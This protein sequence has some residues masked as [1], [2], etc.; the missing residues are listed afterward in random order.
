MTAA[1]LRIAK[2]LW[3]LDANRRQY[4]QG[5]MTYVLNVLRTYSPYFGILRYSEY[6][7]HRITPHTLVNRFASDAF[8]EAKSA[9]EYKASTI[10]H[11]PMYLS[12]F[13]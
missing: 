10:P 7:L 8:H 4:R 13:I 11:I 1:P 2:I 6:H 9:E 5:S 3:Y 12:I